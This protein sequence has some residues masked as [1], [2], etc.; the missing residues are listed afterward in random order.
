MFAG[1]GVGLLSGAFLYALSFPADVIAIASRSILVALAPLAIG[2]IVVGLPTLFVLRRHCTHP[3]VAVVA[4]GALAFGV[5]SLSAVVVAV[6]FGNNVFLAFL[7]L[8]LPVVWCMTVAAAL[9]PWLSSHRGAS[10]AALV[11]VGAASLVGLSHLD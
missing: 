11:L 5:G 3:L 8:G 10:V 4:V 2:T 1:A 9:L 7:T 6:F